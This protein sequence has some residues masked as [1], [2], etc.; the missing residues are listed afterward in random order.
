MASEAPTA[1]PSYPSY[2]SHQAQAR[3]PV[4]APIGVVYNTAMARPDAA[5]ALA[6]LYLFDNKRQARLG[7]VCVA[8]SG[9]NTA[10]FCDI[11]A[12]FY[13]GP[14]RNG[15]QALA[16]GLPDV[17]PMPADPPMVKPALERKKPNG[18]PQYLRSIR[19]LSDTSQA[20]AVL[21]NGIVF[22]AETV[23]VL[24]A[25]ATWIANA[26]DLAGA[27]DQYK[28]RVRRVVI[29]EGDAPQRDPAALRK[30]IADCPAPVFLCGKDVGDALLF[31]GANLDTVFTSAATHP[32]VDA[33]RAFKPMPYD[34]PLHDLAAMHFAVHPDSGF[35][36]LSAPGSLT[37]T[38]QG[39]LRFAE[40]GG[41]VRRLTVDSAKKTEALAA[42]VAI[43]TAVPTPPAPR[44]RGG[45]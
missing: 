40:G 16:V 33:Y 9:L 17:R 12:R 39:A 21:R 27:K 37:V 41:T 28:Q 23:V 19:Q 30:F 25:P 6:A 45:L 15:N 38:D 20:E 42:L 29:V 24:S 10:I 32:I 7:A 26:L 4:M 2:S 31:P 44:G 22:N 43:A 3:G 14:A 34:A 5:L 35:F 18:E 8:G 11:V 1:D 36:A 13:S